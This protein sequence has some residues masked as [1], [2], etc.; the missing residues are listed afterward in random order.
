MITSPPVLIR[1]DMTLQH[2]TPST[3]QLEKLI[4]LAPYVGNTSLY[5]IKNLTENPEVKLFAKLEWQQFGGSVKA[6]AAYRIVRDVVESGK[7]QK[8]KRL[9]DAT[10]GNT[11]IAYAIF[12]AVAGIPLTIVLPENASIERKNIL[13]TLGVEVIFSSPFE[14]TEGAQDL[15]KE[16]VQKNPG[17]YVYLDQYSNPLNTLAHYQSTAPEIWRQTQGEI[18]HFIAGLGTTGTFTG[19]GSRLKEFN[20]DIELIALQPDSALHGLEGW[21]H[22][23]TARTPKIYNP[24]LADQFRAVS[25]EKAYELIPSVAKKEGL[26]LSPSAAANLLGAIELSHELEKGIIVTTFADN[27]DK[28]PEIIKLLLQ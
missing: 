26:H 15:A 16:L 27:A 12:A 11:G 2:K 6:R 14:S 9:L 25:T 17:L 13:N 24:T 21:K 19:T 22:L 1:N 8:G 23:E 4:E 3:Y 7:W 10:S 20:K 28:Y 18:T 5:P